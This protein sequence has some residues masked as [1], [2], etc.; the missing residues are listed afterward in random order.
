MSRGGHRLVVSSSECPPDVPQ[1]LGANQSNH[2]HKSLFA[3]WDTQFSGWLLRVCRDSPS[4]SH[5]PQEWALTI[6]RPIGVPYVCAECLQLATDRPRSG[7]PG[8][9]SA[10][11]GCL[12]SSA[13]GPGRRNRGA[14]AERRRDCLCG[15]R[16]RSRLNFG[17]RRATRGRRHRD[18]RRTL[19]LHSRQPSAAPPE[20]EVAP[21]PR[22]CLR[23]NPPPTPG[24]PS[25]LGRRRTRRHSRPTAGGS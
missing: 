21:A 4:R 9:H 7:R 6:G 3:F 25:R 5:F 20:L 14:L 17:V 1:A 8:L 11:V 22:R 10:G 24:P 13:R 23:A 2:Q 12:W 15:S 16:L 19:A 18:D